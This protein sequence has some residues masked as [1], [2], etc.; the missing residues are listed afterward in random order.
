MND[1][2]DTEIYKIA[3]PIWENMNKC[4]NNIDYEGFSTHFSKGL[5]NLITQ[6]RFVEQCKNHKLLTSLKLGATPVA[7]IRRAEGVGVVF[8][9]L[10]TELEGE[11]I[12]SIVLSESAGTVEVLDATIY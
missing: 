2:S 6:T 10:S 7:C 9:Q 4:S 11:F 8:K 3:A 1:L 12:G 5:K